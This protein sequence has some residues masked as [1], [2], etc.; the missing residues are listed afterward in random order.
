MVRLYNIGTV[1]IDEYTNVTNQGNSSTG[2]D[3]YTDEEVGTF[4]HGETFSL[5]VFPSDETY[6]T[7]GHVNVYIDWN[8]DGDFDDTDEDLG[9]QKQCE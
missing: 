7:D 5:K 4:K 8:D 6:T 9:S 2:Y 3:D 1:N